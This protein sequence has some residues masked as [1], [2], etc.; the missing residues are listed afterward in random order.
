[1]EA[2]LADG[3]VIEKIMELKAKDS[4]LVA[5]IKQFFD[6]LLAKIR[7]VYNGL[8]PDSDEGKAVLEMKDSIEKI[9]QLFA[10]ALVDASENF[11]T[12][13]VQKNTTEDGGEEEIKESIRRTQ[14]MSL[15]EQLSAYYS[16]DPSK[17]FKQSDAFYFGVTP[18]ILSK[19]QFGCKSSCNGT[20]RLQKKHGG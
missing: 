6:N 3:N 13:E 15:T 19:K 10:E 20:R 18:D 4:D 11:Q 5:K 16:K 9:Q 12:A 1:M 8:T 7:N 17:R 2:M 14:K